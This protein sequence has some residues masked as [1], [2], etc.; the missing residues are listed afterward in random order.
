MGKYS[1]EATV[2]TKRE[3]ILEKT[4]LLRYYLIFQNLIIND[5]NN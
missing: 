5:K 2:T 1:S 3:G 4:M